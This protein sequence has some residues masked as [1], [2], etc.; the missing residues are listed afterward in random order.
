MFKLT[1]GSVDARPFH[2]SFH[3]ILITILLNSIAIKMESN[4]CTLSALSTQMLCIARGQFLP[5]SF[6]MDII[7]PSIRIFKPLLKIVKVHL[8]K[9]TA[10]RSNIQEQS[11]PLDKI[12]TSW[13]FADISNMVFT[14]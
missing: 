10:K 14:T 3:V 11:A 5:L 1:T 7:C 13:L 8:S 4:S 6:F 9:W 12:V 2:L